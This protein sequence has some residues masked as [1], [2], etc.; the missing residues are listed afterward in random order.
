MTPTFDIGILGLGGVGSACADVLSSSGF[1]VVGIDRHGCGHDRGSSHGETRIFRTG[2]ARAGY[3]P[4]LEY[5]HRAW[6]D[7]QADTNA[8]LIHAVGH[9]SVTQSDSPLAVA[10]AASPA[11]QRLLE[12]MHG[13]DLRERLPILAGGE[14]T[15][16]WDRAGLV[17]R[18]EDIVRERCRRAERRGATLR[19]EEPVLS[20]S[21]SGAAIDLQTAR[22]RYGCAHLVL[23]GGAW[24]PSLSDR[25]QTLVVRP[26]P[27]AWFALDRSV[28]AASGRAL[29]SF[30]YET[31]EGEFYGC[32]LPD[33]ADIKVGSPS[34]PR[35]IE[36]PGRLPR[37]PTPA[38]VAPIEAFVASRLHAVEGRARAASMCMTTN[39]PSKDFIVC[40]HPDHSNVTIV[41]GLSGHGFK[42]TP[43]IAATVTAMITG[44]RTSISTLAGDLWKLP[45]PAPI[46]APAAARP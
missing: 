5:A 35:E 28:T 13:A 19:F 18:V 38:D 45:L 25:L 9:V 37:R 15:G 39:T 41:A 36:D 27:V 34:L 10:Y 23:A 31:D 2:Y 44:E 7:L 29:P 42:L 4:L 12:P 32:A 1:S 43:T 22:G 6:H 46:A 8:Q 33:A 16:F 26:S 21:R 17:L 40:A 3:V 24:A 11:L 30:T 14:A 20:W